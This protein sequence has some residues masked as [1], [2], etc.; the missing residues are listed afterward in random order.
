M[1][2]GQTDR[3]GA[4]AAGSCTVECDP[5]PARHDLAGK[6][7]PGCS[8]RP[9]IGWPVRRMPGGCS[10]SPDPAR[11]IDRCCRHLRKTAGGPSRPTPCPGIPAGR[12]CRKWL[13]RS[14]WQTRRRARSVPASP[15]TRPRRPS[16]PR[17]MGDV[18]SASMRIGRIDLSWQGLVQ[19]RTRRLIPGR[20]GRTG[21]SDWGDCQGCLD[22]QYCLANSAPKCRSTAFRWPVQALGCARGAPL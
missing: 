4:A 18:A 8:S 5:A 21:T 7:D 19:A 22:S 3:C 13:P 10:I 20:F 15:M 2:A 12:L 1:A 16:R 11:R 14:P 17:P 9:R 6:A